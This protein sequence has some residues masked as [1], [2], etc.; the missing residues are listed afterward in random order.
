[1]PIG[2]KLRQAL[3]PKFPR[4]ELLHKVEVSMTGVEEGGLLVGRLMGTLGLGG[5]GCG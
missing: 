4:R 5:G 3:S 2:M 1:M